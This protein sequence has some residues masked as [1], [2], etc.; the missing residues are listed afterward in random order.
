MVD[1]VKN[2]VDVYAANA[3]KYERMGEW[4]ERIGW[5][6]FFE[7]TGIPFTRYHI[8]D[9]K[10]AGH[11]LRTVAHTSGSRKRGELMSP[12]NSRESRGIDGAS[13][14]LAGAG[15]RYRRAYHRQ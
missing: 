12:E 2:I 5:P 15:N 7:L 3:R 11:E 4:I 13:E 9:F 14:E 6:R 8:D 10:H 1:A